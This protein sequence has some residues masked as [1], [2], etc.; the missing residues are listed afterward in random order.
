MLASAQELSVYRITLGSSLSESHLRCI[1]LLPQGLDHHLAQAPG[2]RA[3]RAAEAERAC[4]VFGAFWP[5]RRFRRR[6]VVRRRPRP[7]VQGLS[8]VPRSKAAPRLPHADLCAALGEEAGA[9]ELAQLAAHPASCFSVCGSRPR[10]GRGIFDGRQV[11][12][13]AQAQVVMPYRLGGVRRR[14][15]L[16]DSHSPGGLSGQPVPPTSTVGARCPAAGRGA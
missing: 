2:G 15:A 5:F 8:G 14:L 9:Q 11:E 12:L 7:A 4:R 1:R 6:P 16:R 3:A 13:L 10:L